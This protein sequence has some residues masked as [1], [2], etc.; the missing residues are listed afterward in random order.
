MKELKMNDLETAVAVL[1]AVSKSLLAVKE[2]FVKDKEEK[3][4]VIR[5]AFNIIRKELDFIEEHSK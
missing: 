2:T 4:Q 1:S 5:Q 3:D